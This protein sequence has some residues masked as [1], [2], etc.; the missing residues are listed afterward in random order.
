MKVIQVGIGN[1]GGAWLQAVLPSTEVQY[2]GFVEINDEIA[3]AQAEKYDLDRSLIF[4]TLEEALASVHADAVIDVTP[5]R[6]HLPIALAAMDAGLH[7]MTE[8][9]LAESL[10]AAAAIARKSQETGLVHMVAQNRRYSAAVQTV[11][12]LLHTGE[13]GRLA[14]VTGTHFRLLN[15]VNNFRTTMAYPLVVDMSIHHFDMLRCLLNSD[16]LTIFGRTWNPPWSSFVHDASASVLIEFQN[17]VVVSYNASWA[18]TG[19]ET[20]FDGDWRFECEHGVIVMKDTK[21]YVGALGDRRTEETD[22]MILTPYPLDD[23]PLHNQ[24][25]LLHEFYEAVTL[26]RQPATT[27]AD[28]L[29]SLAMVFDTIKSFE[30]GQVVVCGVMG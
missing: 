15:L 16:P 19:A 18:S 8:K 11:K 12:R 9:P 22:D 10:E 25:Y 29:K 23:M 13:F 2:A 26:G 27:G 6:F 24:T 17:R 5:P 14:S 3:A 7:V 28:N 21:V 4:K 1:M 20:S 30:T